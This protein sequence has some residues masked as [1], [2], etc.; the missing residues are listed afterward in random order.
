MQSR[1]SVTQAAGRAVH[2]R[3]QDGWAEPG[4]THSST[5]RPVAGAN[6]LRAPSAFTSISVNK[7]FA[8]SSIV[9]DISRTG[10]IRVFSNRSKGRHA[11]EPE[12]AAPAAGRIVGR[13]SPPRVLPS[14]L[15]LA[16]C[17]TRP[18]IG[19]QTDNF[20]FNFAHRVADALLH[21]REFKNSEGR[22]CFRPQN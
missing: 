17:A 18:A 12:F 10:P 21:N 5:I 8:R 11:P 9:A 3:V 15:A 1:R 16:P 20:Q 13:S 19:L 4:R 22:V 2:E 7:D 14:R 6:G